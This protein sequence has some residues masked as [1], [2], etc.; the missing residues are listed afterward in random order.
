MLQGRLSHTATVLADGRVLVVG[1]SPTAA[2][3][4]AEIY[5]PQTNTWSSAAP[6]TSSRVDHTATLLRTGAVLVV[7]GASAELYHPFVGW[8]PAGRLSIARTHHTATLLDD[9]RVLVTGGIDV[10][11]STYA[12]DRVLAAAELY[13]PGTNVWL[14]ATSMRSRRM[15]HTAT[16]LADGRVLVAGGLGSELN[17]RAEM[18]DPRADRWSDAGALPARTAHHAATLLPSRRVLLTG[19]IGAPGDS[20][21][22]PRALATTQVFDPTSDVW[23]LGAGMASPRFGHSATLL[24]NGSVLVAGST[25][26][27]HGG[28][29]LYDPKTNTW[30]PVPGVTIERY[31]YTATVLRDGR[32]LLAGGRAAGVLTRADLYD[33]RVAGMPAPA[34][35]PRRFPARSGLLLGAAALTGA[36]LFL[37]LLGS[38]RP[39][40]DHWIAG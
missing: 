25:P 18:Y 33:P 23:S 11:L 30:S 40:P 4:S 39:R 20:V 29:E 26:L 37:M 38:R 17:D 32:V 8:I 28:A 6:P 5:D 15:D 35:D 16:R 27:G 31:G 10:S 7:S 9:G 3:S 12:V 36:S 19:G 1:G 2:A 22:G 24:R 34:G 14:P 21:T 13:D